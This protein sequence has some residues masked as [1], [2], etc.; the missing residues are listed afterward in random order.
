[1][2][3]RERTHDFQMAQL[4]GTD[5]HEEILAFGIL[6]VEP[7]NRILH[8]RSQLA[9]RPAELLEQ[10]VAKLRIRNVDSN[11]IHQLLHVMVHAASAH[12]H[13]QE[14]VRTRV[15][16]TMRASFAPSR[17][18]PEPRG[19]LHIAHRW[20]DMIAVSQELS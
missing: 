19:G 14:V 16:S 1:V 6:T 10:H 15:R 12:A 13:Y 18:N 8:R 11:G 20:T 3:A 2:Q 9:V 5:V 17:S 4:F 7:L